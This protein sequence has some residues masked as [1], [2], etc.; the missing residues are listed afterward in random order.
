[1]IPHKVDP[2]L[3]TSNVPDPLP[4]ISDF[5]LKSLAL[6]PPPPPSIS[7]QGRGGPLL[8]PLVLHSH[9]N[10]LPALHLLQGVPPL[11][12][13]NVPAPLY[14]ISALPLQ[15]GGPRLQ[16]S[17]VNPPPPISS[18]LLQ[19]DTLTLQPPAVRTAAAPLLSVSII[20]P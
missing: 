15:R 7:L 11:L 2:T 19:L 9:A 18:L 16:T 5:P 20:Q 14:Q 3:Q 4:Q 17:A 1:M 10:L 13:S 8:L 6:N 12:P